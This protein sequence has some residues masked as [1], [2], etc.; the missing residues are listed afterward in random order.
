M[1]KNLLARYQRQIDMVNCSLDNFKNE[2]DKDPA[3][4]LSWGMGAVSSAAELKVLKQVV[5]YLQDGSSVSDLRDC[6]MSKI[7][8]SSRYPSHSTNPLSNLMDQYELAACSKIYAE[9]GNV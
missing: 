8:H 9:L 5:A 7:S 4:A 6:L 1:N 2:F 3:Y